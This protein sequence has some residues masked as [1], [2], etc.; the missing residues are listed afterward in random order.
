MLAQAKR[1]Y[2]RSRSLAG[3]ETSGDPPAYESGVTGCRA[4]G[5]IAGAEVTPLRKARLG[6]RG[7]A[8]VDTADCGSRESVLNEE[9]ARSAF[10]VDEAKPRSQPPG[11]RPRQDEPVDVRIASLPGKRRRG[12]R[13][14]QRHVE[15]QDPVLVCLAVRVRQRGHSVGGDEGTV[16]A[17]RVADPADP[18]VVS[19]PTREGNR[20]SSLRVVAERYGGPFTSIERADHDPR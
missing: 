19:R 14:R 17:A 13:S 12:V 5:Q 7:R 2:L 15:L 6:V 8:T 3:L 10:S 11:R 20:A 18:A 1:D 4:G 16:V 9:A